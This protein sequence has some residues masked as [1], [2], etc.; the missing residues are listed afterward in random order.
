MEQNLNLISHRILFLTTISFI[1]CFASWVINGV[2]VTFLVN[3]RVFIW[4]PVEIGWLLG[5]PILVGSV[6]RLPIGIITDKYG[7]KLVMSSILFFSAIPM[8]FLSQANTFI[9]FLLLGLGFGLAGTSFAAGVAY[10]SLW[11]PK[12]KQGT[13]LGIFGAGNIGASLTTLI[14]PSVLD[15]LTSHG[16]NLDAWRTLPK[17]YAIMLIIVG[18]IF[19]FGTKNKIPHESK[20]MGQR[21]SPLK[22]IRVWRFGLYYFF[23]FGSFVALSQ[24]L[25]PYYVNVYSLSIVTAGFMATAFSLPAGL[26]RAGGGWLADKVGARMVLLWV[27][28][29]CIV[30]LFFL[31]I[32]RMEILAPGQ[33]IMA[34]RPGTVT[35]VSNNE[36][37]VSEDKYFLQNKENDSHQVMIRFGIHND[38]EGFL[39]LPTA[40]ISQE[41]KVKLG[42]TVSKGQ[43]LASG[44][45]HVY[46]Q[47]NRWIFSSLIFLIGIMMG[48]GGAAV[49]KH[50]SDYYP[51]NIGAVGGI[52]G[53]LGGLGGFFGP[54]F[55]GYL[56]RVSGVWTTCWMF[57]ALI[58]AICIVLQRIAIKAIIANGKNKLNTQFKITNRETI[59]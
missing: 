13:V 28:G 29:V 53:V 9:S 1:V 52:V 40:S 23:V 38:N 18:I 36:I 56:L 45:T 21:L 58:A 25:I 46:F 43:L 55:F 59:Q 30:C 20:S 51:T 33:G 8:Y 10:T 47:A 50:I 57:L 17:L 48:I 26:F 7:G 31:F 37:V 22:E 41:P 24:W 49:Y 34:V 54:I 27:F 6:F 2:L 15:K 14:A 4:S 11:Y 44:V 3:N 32:P 35:S 19:L 5:V 39:F 42:D 12:E 16:A